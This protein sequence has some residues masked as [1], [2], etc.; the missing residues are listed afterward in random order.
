MRPQTYVLLLLSLLALTHSATAQNPAAGQ[1]PTPAPQSTSHA[2]VEAGQTLFQEQCAFCHG[3]DAT[4]GE[5]GPDLTA[6]KLVTDDVGGDKIGPVVLN[7]RPEKG[8]PRFNI[9]PK[10]VAALTA[11]IHD[12]K[13][14]TGA[15]QGGRRKVDAAD[16]QTG[17]PDAGKKYFNGAGGCSGCHSPTGDLAGIARRYPPLQLEEHMLYPREAA[18]NITVTLPSGQTLTGRLA[19]RDEFTVGLVDS[20]GQYRSWPAEQVK[21]AIDAPAEA[22]L[23]L[24]EKYT[25]DDVHNL[26]AYLQTLR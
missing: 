2:L 13:T 18:A 1:S 25:D 8:M 23:N 5:T 15:R 12:Q 7:G 26:M 24:L 20:S 6:S 21:F 16:L 9:S 14:K 17:N 4:G 22:H 3:R 11:F 19:Y 10:D